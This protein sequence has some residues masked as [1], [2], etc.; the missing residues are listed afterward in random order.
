MEKETL[1]ELIFRS[2]T[3]RELREEQLLNLFGVSSLEDIPKEKLIDYC[4]KHYCTGG[5]NNGS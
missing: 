3:N 1:L 2:S 5:E 4:N